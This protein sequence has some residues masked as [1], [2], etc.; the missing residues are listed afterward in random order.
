MRKF[1]VF[2]KSWLEYIKLRSVL[3]LKIFQV[4]KEF[5]KSNVVLYVSNKFLHD[6]RVRWSG[7]S[8]V[9]HRHWPDWYYSISGKENLDY[10]SEDIYYSLIEPILNDK[11]MAYAYSDKNMYNKLYAGDIFPK[12]FFRNMHGCTMDGQ[13]RNVAC[14]DD[15]LLEGAKVFL[16]P[17]IES[18]SGQNV[19]LFLRRENGEYFNINGA[20]L[21]R[22]YLDK[23]YAKNYL[24]QSSIDQ[25]DFFSR[26]C[27][28]SVNTIRVQTY[29][30]VKSNKPCVLK[31]VLRIGKQGAAIDNQ[32]AGGVAAELDQHGKAWEYATDK[33]GNKVYTLS[34][35]LRV[36]DIGQVPFFSDIISTAIALAEQMP[37][38]RVLGF[39]ICVDKNGK[40][41]V[42]EI[43]TQ[44]LGILF[45]QTGGKSMFGQYTS[46]VI[47]Y[48]AEYLRSNRI[49]Y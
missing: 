45:F 39:D 5:R 40:I 42:I 28:T 9:V 46:E 19:E 20:R 47:D 32:N 27:S 1:Y 2:I 18:G 14:F 24:I 23:R 21:S 30:S 41:V 8:K 33:I 7:I 43:N 26:L 49:I 35:G 48:C 11:R 22:E 36:Q 29:R 12:V 38:C 25:Y 17:S 10:V 3:L 6:Y 4:G 16:K 37:Y 15:K 34:S 31:A 44:W 13:Y